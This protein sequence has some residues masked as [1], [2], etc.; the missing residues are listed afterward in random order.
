MLLFSRRKKLAEEYEKW[1]LCVNRGSGVTI[2]DCPQAVIGFL[3]ANG[4]LN[5]EKVL[6]YLKEN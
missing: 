1:R 3:N 6:E 4:L 5:E 2:L